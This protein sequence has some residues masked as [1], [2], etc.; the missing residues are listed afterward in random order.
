[1][2]TYLRKSHKIFTCATLNIAQ[3]EKYELLSPIEELLQKTSFI[4]SKSIHSRNAVNTLATQLRR[5]M[6]AAEN[7]Q[8][9]EDC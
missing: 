1:M 6:K 9:V 3:N 2:R 7:L 5:Q 8:I 4:F